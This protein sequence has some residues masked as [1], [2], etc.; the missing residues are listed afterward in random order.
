MLNLFKKNNSHSLL[1]VLL[2]IF[3]VFDLRVPA[4]MANLLDTLL[5]RVVVIG[6]A[7][8]LLF[9]NP[10]LGVLGV[11]AAY[12]L[13]RRSETESSNAGGIG[14]Q[15]AGDLPRVNTQYIPSE[16][17][18]NREYRKLNQFPVTLEESVINNMLPFV[19]DQYLPPATFKPTLAS[20]YDAAKINE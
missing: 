12:E 15:R 16:R 11:V 6:A 5:G 9:V 19:S 7:L 14:W 3:T 4:E 10:L 18:K 13:L 8:S 20:L 1:A 2:V 17:A